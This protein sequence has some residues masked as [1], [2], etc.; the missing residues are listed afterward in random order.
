[1]GTAISLYGRDP[2]T[3]DFFITFILGY[4]WSD[5]PGTHS[6]SQKDE[7]TRSYSPFILPYLGYQLFTHQNNY[8]CPIHTCLINHLMEWLLLQTY[9]DGLP[10]RYSQHLR[11]ITHTCLLLTSG[12]THYD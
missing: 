10:D 12:G 11:S 7:G 4:G 3:P 8:I 9:R 5:A 1:M 6:F 2:P